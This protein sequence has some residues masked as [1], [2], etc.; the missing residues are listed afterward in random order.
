MQVKVPKFIDIEDKVLSFGGF[1]ITWKQ[2][3]GIG[4][5]IGLGGISYMIFEPFIGIPIALI[6][7]ILGGAIAFGRVNERPFIVWL[8]AAIRYYL[9]APRS[10]IWKKQ[11]HRVKFEKG[12]ESVKTSTVEQP[13]ERVAR[14]EVERATL[15][16]NEAE[17][18]RN[19]ARLL[20][21]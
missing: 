4:L 16:Q 12:E 7:M 3:V 15:A 18:V 5:G 1:G 2:G 13:E 11:P 6:C 17:R 8:G 10:Y 21:Q 9:I 19:I 20:D 14:E